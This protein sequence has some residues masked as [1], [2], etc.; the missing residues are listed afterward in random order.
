MSAEWTVASKKKNVRKV[1]NIIPNDVMLNCEYVMW[2]HNIQNKDWSLNGYTKLCNIKTVSE[3]WKLSNNL[4]KLNFKMNN[5]FL[6]KV[7]I[8][9]IWEDPNNRDGGICS[10]RVELDNALAVY[11]LLCVYLMCCKLVQ[12]VDD[13]NGISFTPK[14]NWAIIKIWN[15]DGTNDLAKS[16]HKDILFKYKK[17]SIQYKKN[18]PE[19]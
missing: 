12:S 5:F 7:G 6:M 10:F 9:P 17:I 18:E 1:P 13:I 15:K 19:Y 8:N 14:N 2:C 3:F 16:L 4:D 11:E